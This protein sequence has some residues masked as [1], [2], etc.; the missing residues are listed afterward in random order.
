MER[1][2]RQL[3]LGATAAA[4]GPYVDAGFTSFDMA[5]HYGSAE[6]IAGRCRS[7]RKRDEIQ[8]FT[9]WVPEPGPTT[10]DT[11]RQAV[12][13][14]LKRLQTE[15]LDL[16]QYHAWNYADPSYLDG[17]FY[18]QELK[19]E[20]LIKQLG[21]TNFDTTHLNIILNSG[22]EVVSNQVC[23]SLLD[24]RATGK[25]TAICREHGIKLLAFG[26][27]AGGLLSER[28]LGKPQPKAKE[29]STWSQ[30]KY[31]RYIDTAGG[32]Q[33]FQN[34]LRT[35]NAI[36]KDHGVSVANVATRCILDEPS[37][38][39]IIV[40][41]RLGESE[42]IADNLRLFEFSLSDTDQGRINE[43]LRALTPIP[44]DCGDEYRKPPYLTASGD[45]SH[46]IDTLPAPFETRDSEDGR[47]RALSGT[48]WE[49]LAG[50][51][52]AIRVGD[53]ILVS[54]TT[55][56][57]GNRVIGG[58]DPAAQ[59]H[60]AIDKIDGAIQSL[61]GRLEQVVRT[62]VY[63]KNM[64][65]GEKVFRAH[66]ERFGHILPANTHVQAGILGDDYLIEI[67]A[68]AVVSE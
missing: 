10:R 29:A 64:A 21:V 4:M 5:D 11:V 31:L 28:W 65:D 33:V 60:F 47:T 52:R 45:L 23:F 2:S 62:R 18:L 39:G 35:L 25:M 32:W 9:K 34:L 43:A 27:L 50:F 68:E 49:D 56:T 13:L 19:G 54:G 26:T 30:M 8:L 40:G 24:Q 7:Q 63:F 46:H 51:S 12:E 16:L 59:M 22:I 48:I 58:K 15:Q 53:R 67:E 42:H 55:A 37:V 61:G 6:V 14:A 20:G 36:A 57:H 41:A 3:D 38:A 17:L 66:G 1:E 44:G